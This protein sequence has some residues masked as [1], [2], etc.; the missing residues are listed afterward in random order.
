MGKW[1]ELVDAL[2]EETL[3]DPDYFIGRACSDLP[4]SVDWVKRV[5]IDEFDLQ[6]IEQGDISMECLIAHIKL[7]IKEHKIVE[8]RR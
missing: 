8:M 3:I 7:K 6:V 4:V 2:E 1:L 5:V